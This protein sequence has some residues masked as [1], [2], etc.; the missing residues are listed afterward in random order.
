MLN[1]LIKK[2]NLPIIRLKIVKYT[3]KWLIIILNLCSEQFLY[4]NDLDIIS[5]KL[6]I[7][8]LPLVPVSQPNIHLSWLIVAEIK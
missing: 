3:H 2:K 6:S 5:L 8:R 1:R 4:R 7:F